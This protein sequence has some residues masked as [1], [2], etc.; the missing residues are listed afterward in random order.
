ML[1]GQLLTMHNV[2]FMMR[3]GKEIRRSIK[4]GNFLEK[5]CF[6]LSP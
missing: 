2:A 4:N 6:R 1:G 3:L 5:A